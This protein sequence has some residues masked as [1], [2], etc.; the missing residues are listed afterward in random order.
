MHSYIGPVASQLL[1]IANAEK[2]VAMKA[3]MKNKFEFLGIPSPERRTVCKSY[4][5]QHKLQEE[6]ELET[7][8]K[9]LWMLPER[10]F[11][12]FGMELLAY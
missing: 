2:A 7:I 11:Q 8:V 6:K 1:A 5:K 3:Y 9:E 12:Y 4:M 10:E